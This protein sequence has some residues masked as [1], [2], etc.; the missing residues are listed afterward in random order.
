MKRKI[1]ALMLATVSAVSM[2]CPTI[3]AEEKEQWITTTINGVDFKFDTYNGIIEKAVKSSTIGGDTTP[4]ANLKTYHV[5]IPS[6]IEGVTVTGT[7]KNAFCDGDDLAEVKLPSTVTTLG[8]YTFAGCDNITSVTI[9]SGV[10]EI[11]RDCFSRCDNLSNVTL[12]KNIKKIGMN[13]FFKCSSLASISIPASVTEIEGSAFAFSGLKSIVIPKTV[14]SIKDS[15]FKSSDLKQATVNAGIQAIP[16]NMFADCSSL[17][18]VTIGNG[19]AKIDLSSFLNCKNLTSVTIPDSVKTIANNAFNGCPKVTIYCSKGSA[20]ET[21]AI[22]NGISYKTNQGGQ[23]V[24]SVVP[25]TIT[26]T[27]NGEVLNLSQPPVNRGGSVLVPMR[28]IFEALGAEITW[29]QN[30]K[31]IYAK[32]GVT[33]VTCW[34]DSDKAVVN[35][36]TIKLPAKPQ[37]VNGATVVPARFVAETFGANVSWNAETQTVSIVVK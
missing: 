22:K 28:A 13:A 16:T 20:A 1:I 5:T 3:M 29:Y 4:K 12:N 6:S 9:P 37:I 11:P 26:V 36:Q 10:S 34:I 30:E 27:I 19:I 21:Y 35:G 2:L 17:E 18:S 24:V 7:S 31:K 23:S 33:N 15:A 32:K 14:T 25:D 8:D